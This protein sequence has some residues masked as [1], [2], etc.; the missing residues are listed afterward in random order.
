MSIHLAPMDRGES[1][2]LVRRKN[3]EIKMQVATSAARTASRASTP[4]DLPDDLA[5]QQEQLDNRVLM[6]AAHY[7]PE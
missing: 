6:S 3:A 7:Q 5:D 4:D 2:T 1:M